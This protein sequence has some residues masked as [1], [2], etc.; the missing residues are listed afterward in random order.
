M[1]YMSARNDP[2]EPEMPFYKSAEDLATAQ[3]APLKGEVTTGDKANWP[4]ES[5]ETLTARRHA[6]VERTTLVL[7]GTAKLTNAETQAIVAAVREAAINEVRDEL[8]ATGID[9]SK[10][11]DRLIARG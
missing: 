11:L 3:S 7:Q 9:A 4:D 6:S 10:L 5:S 2:E 1:F 8:A